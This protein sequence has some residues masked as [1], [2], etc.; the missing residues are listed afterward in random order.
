MSWVLLASANEPINPIYIVLVLFALAFSAVWLIAMLII[1]SLGWKQLAYNY[2]LEG[3]LPPN[4]V[5]YAFQSA[6]AGEGFTSPRYNSCMHGWIDSSGLYLRPAML[7]RIFH[8]MLLI[9]WSDI[10]AIKPP[11]MGWLGGQ[12][13]DLGTHST[14]ITLFGRLGRAVVTEWSART[15]RAVTQ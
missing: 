5:R 4:S 8:P 2:R 12:H 9:R 15:G 6:R 3:T 1:S 13:L 11:K 10:K 14:G 7:F